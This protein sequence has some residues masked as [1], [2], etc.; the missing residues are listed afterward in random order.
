[1]MLSAEI[2]REYFN[3]LIGRVLHVGVLL[4]F[5]Y[6]SRLK[7]PRGSFVECL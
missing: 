3:T 2:V 6:F 4:S 7:V 1:M 5:Q